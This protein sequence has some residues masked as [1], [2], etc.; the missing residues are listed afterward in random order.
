MPAKILLP[1]CIILA[2][3]F[4][5]PPSQNQERG[6]D[7]QAGRHIVGQ[8]CLWTDQPARQRASEKSDFSTLPRVRA[9]V[10]FGDRQQQYSHC[11]QTG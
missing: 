2:F 3:F 8:C 1:I 4:F 7:C 9:R 11:F 6:S 10:V 5:P